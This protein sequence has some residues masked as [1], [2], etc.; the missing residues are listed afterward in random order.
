MRRKGLVKLKD[1]KGVGSTIATEATPRTTVPSEAPPVLPDR[2]QP[3][4]CPPWSHR[5]PWF[6]HTFEVSTNPLRPLH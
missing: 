3:P 5:L 2:N 4:G 6:Q 1:I